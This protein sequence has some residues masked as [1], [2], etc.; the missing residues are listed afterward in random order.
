[1][2]NLANP[3][4]VVFHGW[5]L[6]RRLWQI[7]LRYF[8]EIARFVRIYLINRG[9]FEF[10]S[11]FRKKRDQ[12]RLRTIQRSAMNLE[13]I[14]E[15]I[16][17]RIPAQL[18]A[19][20]VETL[21]QGGATRIERIVSK[22]QCSPPGFWYDQDDNEWVLL[23]RGEATLR[24]EKDDRTIHLVAGSYINIAAHERHRVEW[25]KEDTETIWLAVF[26]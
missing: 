11:V 5:G 4:E 21:A 19:E 8:H 1:M 23:L 22:G 9:N 16:F 13:N 25:T 17:S 18:P 24:F 7:I 2:P 10:N 12:Q 20:A 26:Y 3:C 14:L 6:W 15:N